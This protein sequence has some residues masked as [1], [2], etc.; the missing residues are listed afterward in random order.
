MSTAAKEKVAYRPF[1]KWAGGKSKLITQY[2]EFFP[3][4]FTNYYEPFLG[5]GALFF[6]LCQTRLNFK[7]V[8][9]DINADL[10]NTY[11]CVKNNVGELVKI[12]EEHQQ[13]HNQ[14]YYYD[15][16]SRN[17]LQGLESA[18][19]L[20]YLNKTC[21]NGLYRVNPKGEFNVPLGKYKNP[22]IC[23]SDLLYSVAE[24]L[25]SADIELRDFTAVLEYAKTSDDFVYF[26][27]P[28][29]PLS[30]TSNFTA[31]SRNAFSKDDQIKLRDVFA[32]LAKRGVKV[33][34]SNSDCDFI[35]EL[36]SDF[37]IVNISAARSINSN[38][39]KRGMI[40]EILVVSG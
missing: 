39:K 24:A 4:A 15:L 10:I 23:N 28:Y 9:T 26:D 32:E 6:H 36:Y 17:D 19:R 20:I 14:Y 25:Q 40:S 27:P 7:A 33:M 29:H 12:L 30:P 21:F 38:A 8:L 11:C 1:L 22:K 34:L 18:A 2:E 13:K 3:K 31:Y 16:R 5:G 35:R 37:N